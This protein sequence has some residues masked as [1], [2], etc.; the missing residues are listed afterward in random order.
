MRAVVTGAAGFIGSHLCDRLLH[1]GHQVA[2]IDCFSDYYPRPLKE[3]NLELARQHQ[4]FALYELDLVEDDTREALDGA[5]VVFHLAGRSGIRP[6]RRNP[7][8]HFLRDNVVATQRLLDALAG[9][10]VRRFVYGGGWSV[11]G[12]AERVPTKESSVPQPLS[13]DGVTKLAS[14]NL[15]RLQAVNH[16]PSSVCLRYFTVY[17]PRQRPDMAVARFMSALAAGDEI[18]IFGDGEQTRDLTFIT[19]VVEATIQAAQA[20]VDGMVLNVGGGSRTTINHLLRCLE[21]T[22]GAT[23]LAR[24]LPATPGDQR[25]TAASINLARRHLRWE[26]RVALSEGLARQWDWFQKSAG[27]KRRLPAWT[28]V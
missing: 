7:F 27:R 14:E 4:K 24:R 16:G 17:G 25:H 13:W 22:T 3:A 11:Y 12:D 2:G 18:E 1:G 9:T 15:V 5:D 8:D 23:A 28:A 19:D 21:E 26:P 20:P 10:S 6:G